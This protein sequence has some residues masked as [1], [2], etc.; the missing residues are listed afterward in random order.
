MKIYPAKTKDCIK[1]ILKAMLLGV[2]F[3]GIGAM[4]FLYS[5]VEYMLKHNIKDTKSTWNESYEDAI[6]DR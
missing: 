3:C 4:A 1:K 5:A 2:C 6:I